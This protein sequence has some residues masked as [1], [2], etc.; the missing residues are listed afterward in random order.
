MNQ[1]I[2]PRPT[3]TE[4]LSAEET[5]LLEQTLDEVLREQWG[6]DRYEAYTQPRP[7]PTGLTPLSLAAE[8]A[9]VVAGGDE[10]SPAR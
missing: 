10:R 2:A 1:P 7:T 5:A 3:L 8:S 9:V 6:P 4:L